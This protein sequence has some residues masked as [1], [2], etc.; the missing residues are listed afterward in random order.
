MLFCA[1]PDL[2]Q[3][4]RQNYCNNFRTSGLQDFDG[5]S[6]SYEQYYALAIEGLWESDIYQNINSNYN[7][8]SEYNSA[9]NSAIGA[10]NQNCTN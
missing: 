4:R 10:S 9:K 7:S 5:N 1:D 3:G 8:W 2:H 6:L